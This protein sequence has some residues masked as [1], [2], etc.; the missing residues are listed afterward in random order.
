MKTNKEIERLLDEAQ[1]EGRCIMNATAAQRR[2]L[3]RRVQC[4][5]VVRPMPG[6]YA[7]SAYWNQLD[8]AERKRHVIRC[9]GRRHPHWV[10]GGIAAVSMHGVDH[11]REA[12]ESGIV[13]ISDKHRSQTMSAHVVHRYERNCPYVVID[14]VRVLPPERAIAESMRDYGFINAVVVASC[15]LRNGMTK[16]RIGHELRAVGGCGADAWHALEVA[17]GGCE[18]GGEAR[19]IAV[20]DLLGVVPPFTQREFV[21]PQTGRTKRTDFAWRMADGGWLVG[22]LDGRDKYVDP[23]MTGGRSVEEIVDAERERER[24]LERAGVKGIVRFRIR[25]T[26]HPQQFAHKLRAAGVPFVIR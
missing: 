21:D 25:D 8:S 26:Y 16:E 3:G 22:E 6:L 5:E 9:L 20:F 19:S 12:D 13:V 1:H 10:F 18:N 15:A 17:D 14:G 2:A 7:R 4:G 23:S 24:A 11:E